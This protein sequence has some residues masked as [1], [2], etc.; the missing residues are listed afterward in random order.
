M[1]ILYILWRDEKEYIY[2]PLKQS[3]NEFK[4]SRPFFFLFFCF[5]RT[6]LLCCVVG[7]FY[8]NVVVN[9]HYGMHNGRTLHCSVVIF[10]KS[11]CIKGN[12][13]VSLL[14]YQA[15]LFFRSSLF[16]RA[17]F[18]FWKIKKRWHCWLLCTIYIYT[19]LML[20]MLVLFTAVKSRIFC[21]FTSQNEW[22]QFNS[23]VNAWQRNHIPKWKNIFSARSVQQLSSKHWNILYIY[24]WKQ[25]QKTRQQNILIWLFQCVRF[26]WFSRFSLE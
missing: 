11:F 13:L 7:N 24:I 17:W 26:P 8:R 4:L 1:T 2:T 16:F 6:P 3:V 5:S 23:Y 15:C 22:P 25:Q 19:S 12:T 14:H 21:Y 9:F 20:L 10:S 18:R